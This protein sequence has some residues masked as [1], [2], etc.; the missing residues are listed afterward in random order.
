MQVTILQGE[1]GSGKSSQLPQILYKNYRPSNG[2]TKREARIYVTQPRRIAAISLARRVATEMGE[3]CGK[4]VG[5]LIGQERSVSE[6][7][8]VIFVTTGWLL[9]KL[10]FNPDFFYGLTHLVLDEIHEVWIYI[11]YT[12]T[13]Y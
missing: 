9:Q 8:R 11:T 1:T 13:D 3:T 5:F 6:Q 12:Y 2:S 7:T 4:T 10:I